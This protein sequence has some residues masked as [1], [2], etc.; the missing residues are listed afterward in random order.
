VKE[1]VAIRSAGPRDF[2][3]LCELYRH[4]VTC[5]PLG[6]IQDLAFHGSLIEKLPMWRKTG[7]DL[8]VAAGGR[9]VVGLGGLAPQTA[10]S[11]ELCKLHVDP[12]WQGQ[13][14][15]RRIAVELVERAYR[16]GFSEVV[17]HVTATQKVAIALY[18]RLGFREMSRKL[19]TTTV[20][21]AAVSFDTIHMTLLL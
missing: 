13:G 1:C 8:L 3:P 6:F 2:E 19:F 11:A 18:R 14:I 10:Q 12:E 15:G 20:F 4:S 16:A 7:G 5:N 17:L 9:K 21:G